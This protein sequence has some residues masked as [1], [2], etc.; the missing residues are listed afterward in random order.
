MESPHVRARVCRRSSPARPTRRRTETC[1][2][3]LLHRWWHRR[4]PDLRCGEA[5]LAERSACNKMA[6]RQARTNFVA[7][8]ACDRGML[9]HVVAPEKRSEFAFRPLPADEG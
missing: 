9:P 4:R 8:G 6:L 1:P 5:G 2:N 7:F 3:R